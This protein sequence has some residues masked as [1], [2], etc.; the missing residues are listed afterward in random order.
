MEGT[1]YVLSNMEMVNWVD[2]HYPHATV[3][4]AGNWKADDEPR[5]SPPIGPGDPHQTAIAFSSDQAYFAG[6][7]PALLSVL[8]HHANMPLVVIDDGL[9]K[10]QVR[11]LQQYCEVFP[12]RNPLKEYPPWSCLDV[13]FLNYDRIVYLDSDT[14]TIRSLPALIESKAEFAAVRNIDWTIKENFHDPAILDRY[15]I[16]L[17]VTAFNAGVFS[18]DN[19]IWGDGRLFHEAK[20]IYDEVGSSFIYPDQS[21]LHILMNTPDRRVTFIENGYNVMAECWDWYQPL[22]ELRLIHYAGNEIKPWNPLCRY[23][24]LELF[25]SY[26]K[27]R[28]L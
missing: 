12:S 10:A 6:L 23:P 21:V 18:I 28:R 25:F 22:K 11:Y 9:T 3:D 8:D 26:S 2:A 19:C 1:G 5:Y 7:M 17:D 14:I 13:S 4:E 20:K 24:K 27:I 16:A 15:G